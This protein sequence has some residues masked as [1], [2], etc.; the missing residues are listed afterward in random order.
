MDQKWLFLLQNSSKQVVPASLSSPLQTI[1]IALGLGKKCTQ[2][3]AAPVNKNYFLSF[4]HEWHGHQTIHDT[5]DDKRFWKLGNYFYISLS[6]FLL[7]L[8]SP[9]KILTFDNTS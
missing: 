3:P 1:Y 8:L 6:F 4:N 7:L 9:Q 5:A 2:T